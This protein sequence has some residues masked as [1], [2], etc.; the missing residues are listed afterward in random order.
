MLEQLRAVPAWQL[1]EHRLGV[2]IDRRLDTLAKMPGDASLAEIQRLLGQIEAL[3]MV[4]RE[5]Q[6]LQK[7][8]DRAVKAS[9]AHGA[10]RAT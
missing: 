6:Q 4:T 8:W 1:I 9:P 10:M 5:P 3:R 7:E 2:L